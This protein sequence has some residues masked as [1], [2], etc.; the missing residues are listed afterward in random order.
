MLKY[1]KAFRAADD[2]NVNWNFVKSASN[3]LATKILINCDSTT[4]RARPTPREMTPII[5]VSKKRIRDI[6]L[7]DIP[8]VK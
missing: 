2:E 7:F 5:R 1:N 3:I 6:F 8:R 4:P